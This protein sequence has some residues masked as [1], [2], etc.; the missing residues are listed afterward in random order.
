MK[1][2]RRIMFAVLAVSAIVALSPG[3]LRAQKLRDKI[4]GFFLEKVDD[5][6]LQQEVE[7]TFHTFNHDG[8]ER[9]YYL[10]IPSKWDKKTPL[11]VVFLF[12]G[13]G[14]G[15]RG[16][17]YYYELEPKAEKEG[18]LLVAPNGTGE[19]DHVLLTWNVEFGFGY[20]QKNKVNDTGFVN[21]LLD[22]LM[23][24]FPID[25]KRIYATGL[26]N[27]AIFC[28]FL[29][30]QPGNRFAAIAPVVGTAGGRDPEEKDFHVPPKPQTPVSV[31]ILQGL[32]DKSV[33][34]EGGLQK[35][36]IADPKVMMSA[37]DTIDFWVQANGCN[38]SLPP[39]I[40]K[41]KNATLHHFSGGKNGTEVS[42]WVIHD[43]GHAW[44]GS[45]RV[46][47]KKWSDKPSA[48]F[49]GNDIIWEFFK[50]HP[51]P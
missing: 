24:R 13:G 51:R 3:E 32:I 17:L 9:S 44:P 34:I 2:A 37:S 12:H 1:N 49:P 48:T 46:P 7:S 40:D 33:P 45:T 41:Q 43:M 39:V 8:R 30:A 38:I 31:L 36:S 47:R 25:E 35:K 19:N 16:S 26:S 14:G 29:A 15:G 27:G 21:A 6:A 42:A 22:D 23:T 18:F 11:P 4:K 5:K 50:T 28:H 10:Y 20:A